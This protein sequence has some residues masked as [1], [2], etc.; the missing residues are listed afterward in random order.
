MTQHCW[1]LPPRDGIMGYRHRPAR[2]PSEPGQ[3]R[4]GGGA[5]K[6]SEVADEVIRLARATREYWDA[7]LPKRHPDYPVVHPGEDSG[8]PPP[9]EAELRTLLQT[10]PEDVVYKLLLLTHIGQG[11]FDWRDLPGDF[12]RLK[13]TFAEPAR[14][15]ELLLAT[16][17]LADYLADGLA[18]LRESKIDPDKLSFK[19][20]RQRK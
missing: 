12:G 5:V 8:P 14:V 13:Q 15:V 2:V 10:L 1:A 20:A 7:E 19:P 3:G 17:P 6:L 4:R 11:D 9:Q 16:V 18:T